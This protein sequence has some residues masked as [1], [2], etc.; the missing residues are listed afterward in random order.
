MID[1][2]CLKRYHWRPEMWEIHLI[3]RIA[4]D[5]T[6]KKRLIKFNTG[7]NI[8]NIP[9]LEWTKQSLATTWSIYK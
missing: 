4:Y 1:D 9:K 8:L 2:S 5:K 7:K 6:K 3:I